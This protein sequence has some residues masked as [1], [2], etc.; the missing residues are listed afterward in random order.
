MAPVTSSM[1]PI[2]P[3]GI[4]LRTQLRNSGSAKK[5]AVIGVSRKVGA[6][7][8]TRIFSGAS[9]TAMAL[10]RPSIAC[11]VMQYTVR[12]SAPTRPI[13]EVT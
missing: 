6:I 7:A 13:W 10:V 11:L 1:R 9:S 3:S 5:E 12:R 2:R 4:L 8:F